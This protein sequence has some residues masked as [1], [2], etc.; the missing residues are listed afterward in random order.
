MLFRSE[1]EGL[2]GSSFE[3]AQYETLAALCAALGQHYP[4]E[5]VA[6]HEHIAPGRKQDPGAGFRWGLLRQVLAWPDRCFPREGA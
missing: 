1:L 3:P 5:H 2:E 6:G 4:I